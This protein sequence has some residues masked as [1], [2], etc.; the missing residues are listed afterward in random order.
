MH[1]KGAAAQCSAHIAHKPQYTVRESA[2]VIFCFLLLEA[3][4]GQTEQACKRL[5]FGSLKPARVSLIGVRCQQSQAI[6]NL[7]VLCREAVN[8]VS[9]ELSSGNSYSPELGSGASL[10]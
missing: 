5:E 3:G 10:S 7:S 4:A 8:M 1:E 2:S 9:E 6:S